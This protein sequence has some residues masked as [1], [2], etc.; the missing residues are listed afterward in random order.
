MRKGILALEAIGF[1]D[2]AF[3]KELTELIEKMRE[4]NKGIRR[5]GELLESEGA[6]AILACV[7]KYTNLTVIYGGDGGPAIIP[8][9]IRNDHIFYDKYLSEHPEIIELVVKNLKQ[10]KKASFA[11]VDL[12]NSKVDGYFAELENKLFM[13]AS[14]F[15]KIEGSAFQ[16]LSSREWA[17]IVLN[18]IGHAFTFLEFSLRFA[19]TNEVLSYLSLKHSEGGDQYKASVKVAAN[20]FKLTEK[21][22]EVLEKAKSD[23]EM[24][25]LFLSIQD[26]RTRSELGSSWYDSVSC[27]QLADQFATRHGAGVE[28]VTAL[29]K[30][31]GLSQS[32]KLSLIFSLVRFIAVIAGVFVSGGIGWLL[33]Y[34]FIQALN[35]WVQATS[36]PV[37]DNSEYRP[38]RVLQDLIEKIKDVNLPRDELKALLEQIDQMAEVT[39]KHKNINQVERYFA[40]LVSSTY[41]RN[42]NLEI[43]QKQLESIASNPLFVSAAKLKT[44]AQ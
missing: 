19:T 6:K 33:F 1:Q 13:P 5:L 8:A 26:Q 18:E 35:T 2:G 15:M 31:G 39:E 43:L 41:R 37:Y 34:V 28:L 17:A 16:V 3:Y 7:K 40:L 38:K 21:E 11:S 27:E 23:E 9:P 20:I 29:E 32:G 14:F 12:V 42:Y 30:I 36:K 4:D 10:V 24:A 22:A 44:L 25:V